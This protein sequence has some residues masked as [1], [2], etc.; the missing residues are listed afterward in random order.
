VRDLALANVHASAILRHL[1]HGVT[2][3]MADRKELALRAPDK[4]G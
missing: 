2:L 4:E 3:A 1:T